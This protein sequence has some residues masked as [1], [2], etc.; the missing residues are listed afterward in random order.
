MARYDKAVPGVGTHRAPVAA[1]WVTADLNKIFA[2]GLNASGQL[3]KGGGVSG[4]VGVLVVDKPKA[5]GEVVDYMNAGEIVEAALSDGTTPIAAGVTVYG[6]AASGLLSVTST[7]NFPVG[8]TVE[9][10]AVANTRL[11][12]TVPKVGAAA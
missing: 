8:H 12:V 5:V 11:V 10:G 1:A 7:G 3:V 4:I 9:G 6:I 2:V